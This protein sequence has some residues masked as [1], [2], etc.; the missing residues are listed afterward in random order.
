VRATISLNE[1]LVCVENRVVQLAQ[2]LR[3]CLAKR[4]DAPRLLDAGLEAGF[5]WTGRVVLEDGSLGEGEQTVSF[6]F[7]RESTLYERALE[8]SPDDVNLRRRFPKGFRGLPG[9]H[10]QRHSPETWDRIHVV[11]EGT[12]PGSEGGECVE[13]F[14]VDLFRSGVFDPDGDMSDELASRRLDL[15]RSMGLPDYVAPVEGLLGHPV[16][17]RACAGFARS[18]V[19]M[20]P[21]SSDVIVPLMAFYH[22]MAYARLALRLGVRWGARIG[23]VLQVRVGC[24]SWH[25]RRGRMR[26]YFEAKPKGWAEMGKFGLDTGTLQAMLDLRALSNARWHGGKRDENGR[27]WL[28]ELPSGD[29]SRRDLGEARYIMTNASRAIRKEELTNFARVLL[30]G[31]FDLE[32]HDGRRI[33]ATAL[34][35]EGVSYD[36]MGELLHHSPGSDEARTYDYSHE[37]DGE[38]AGVSIARTAEVATVGTIL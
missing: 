32:S 27:P 31:V 10:G 8:R 13:P 16:T 26:P 37:I 20:D 12:M 11:Y 18:D 35:L 1:L 22:A 15:V 5:E 30:C 19:S 7:V 4:P 21:G 25:R 36:L 2:L 24:V 34:G 14:F 9:F 29:F 6:A 33:F 3:A 23:E 17:A 38:D 28:P